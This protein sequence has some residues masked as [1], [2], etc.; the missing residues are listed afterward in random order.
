MLRGLAVAAT[1]ESPRSCREP[2]GRACPGF[3]FLPLGFE[4][5][6]EGAWRRGQS[7]V[8]RLEFFKPYCVAGPVLCFRDM[9]RGTCFCPEEA[10]VLW[11]GDAGRE[12][13]Q[14]H[15]TSDSMINTWHQGSL[16]GGINLW[17]SW[18]RLPKGGALWGRYERKSG[19]LLEREKE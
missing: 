16:E 9:W 7:F 18:G 2:S 1:L 13:K 8:I 15:V 4:L 11:G 3:V 10:H 17:R 6:R 12:D 19:V 5:V 14:T